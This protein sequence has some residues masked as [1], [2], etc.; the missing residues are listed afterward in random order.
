MS[1]PRP[2]LTVSH[3]GTVSLMQALSS[4][5]TDWIAE[6]VDAPDW[7]WMGGAVAIE[8]RCVQAIIDGAIGDGLTVLA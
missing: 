4:A 5:G 3:H 6:N 8:P 7:A 2:D 1:V